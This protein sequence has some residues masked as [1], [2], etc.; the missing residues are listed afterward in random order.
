MQISPPRSERCRM[1]ILNEPTLVLN[2]NWQPI[3]FLPVKTAI[4]T[5]LRDMASV[6]EPENYY[7]L[8]FDGWCEEAPENSRWIKTSTSRVPAPEVIVLKKY[9]ERPPRKINFN[10]PNLARRD[11]YTCQY[12]G[13]TLGLGKLTVEHIMP[14][15]RGGPTTW[16]NC[17]A[18]CRTCN[19]RKADKTPKEAGMKL[20]KEP[21]K[22][23]WDP[24]LRIPQGILR[25]SWEPFLAKEIA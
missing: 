17:V 19:S 22:P 6:M 3:T 18:A 24:K 15:S 1:S 10:R 14:R 8:D 12:C 5:V 25:P 11:D 2:R 9:G 4:C 23:K 16:D 13:D 21:R 7:L 20:R